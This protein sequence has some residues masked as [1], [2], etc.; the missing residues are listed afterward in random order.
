MAISAAATPL[1]DAGAMVR[2]LALSIGFGVGG[3]AVF[4]LGIWAL[5]GS[6]YGDPTRATSRRALLLVVAISCWALTL[7]AIGL[8][9][10]AMLQKP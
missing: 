10:W 2:V 1:L 4:C 7:V 5:S 3:V 6:G 9:L 8:G